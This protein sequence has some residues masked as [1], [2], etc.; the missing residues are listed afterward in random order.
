MPAGEPN[1]LKWE[2]KVENVDAEAEEGVL[3]ASGL[4]P[5]NLR[6]HDDTSIDSA[7]PARAL[8]VRS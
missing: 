7:V 3:G 4:V 6:V 8:N 1:K 5:L 2:K